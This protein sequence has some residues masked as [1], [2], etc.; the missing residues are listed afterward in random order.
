LTAVQHV[1]GVPI[2][3]SHP[4]WLTLRLLPMIPPH[5]SKSCISSMSPA[6]VCVFVTYSRM[7]Q[8]LSKHFWI[9][10]GV[11]VVQ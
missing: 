7:R 6:R 1:P 5:S 4:V 8:L 11:G 3:L 2:Y 10:L 9:V